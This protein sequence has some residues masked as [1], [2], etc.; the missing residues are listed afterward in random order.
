VTAPI[1]K[2]E[3]ASTGS[4]GRCRSSAFSRLHRSPGSPVLDADT[5]FV[6][7]TG[8][9]MTRRDRKLCLGHHRQRK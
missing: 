2:D 8:D 6:D 5:D 3:I 7:V 1:R 9:F 4:C